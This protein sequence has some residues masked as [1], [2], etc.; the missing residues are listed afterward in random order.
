LTAGLYT[1]AGAGAKCTDRSGVLRLLLC[2]LL[3]F[4]SDFFGTLIR[5]VFGVR[6]ADDDPSACMLAARPLRDDLRLEDVE[7]GLDL[8][9]VFVAVVSSPLLSA[10]S[11]TGVTNPEAEAAPG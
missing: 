11:F 8:M 4:P 5:D 6:D 7:D 9:V 3:V 10:V 2:E 1:G